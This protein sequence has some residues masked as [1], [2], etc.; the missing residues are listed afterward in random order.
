[1][2][3]PHTLSTPDYQLQYRPDLQLLILRWLR[4]L[5]LPD[6]Q[7]SCRQLL[8]LALECQ[9]AHWL[10]DGRREGPIN[11]PVTQWLT[12][13]FFPEAVRSLAPHPL[14]LAALRS[15]ARLQQL[16][17][18]TT[19]APAVHRALA[20]EQPYHTAVFLTEAEALAWLTAQPH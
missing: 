18:D 1:M 13:E 8:A 16:S 5:S 14:F 11:L 6:M 4:P 2:Q 15:P 10:L 7:A 3:L 19:V 12:E 17:S 20:P 9:C